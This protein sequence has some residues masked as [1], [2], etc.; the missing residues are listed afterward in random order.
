[1][2]MDGWAAVGRARLDH[3]VRG[4]LLIVLGVLVVLAAAGGV[5]FLSAA[6]SYAVGVA[7]GVPLLYAG[8]ERATMPSS[9]RVIPGPVPPPPT[10]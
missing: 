1:M 9:A 4:N 7:V 5:A 8:F 2:L 3:V 10:S 6:T